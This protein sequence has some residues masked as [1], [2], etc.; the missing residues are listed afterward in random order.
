[1]ASV[2]F[3]IPTDPKTLQAFVALLK[4][5]DDA[6]LKAV[7]HPTI[8]ADEKGNVTVPAAKLQEIMDTLEYSQQRTSDITR[9]TR[10]IIRDISQ[11]LTPSIFDQS[12]LQ[13][14][15]A[16]NHLDILCVSFF[17]LQMM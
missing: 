12:R 5:E 2:E 10:N 3:K 7:L 13:Q 8:K 17:L 15:V 14:L 11:H 6:M 1:M 9:L 4:K 16:D